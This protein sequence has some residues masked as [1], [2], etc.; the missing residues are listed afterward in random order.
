MDLKPFVLMHFWMIH[1]LDQIQF[2]Y[3]QIAFFGDQLAET[4]NERGIHYAVANLKFCCGNH[5]GLLRSR[6]PPPLS[7]A[8]LWL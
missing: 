6:L 1:G 8:L 4:I 7:A 3:R 5:C 2:G